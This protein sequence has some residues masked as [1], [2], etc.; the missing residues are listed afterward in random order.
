MLPVLRP[1]LEG[2]LVPLE[3]CLYAT[4][5]TSYLDFEKEIFITFRLFWR[6]IEGE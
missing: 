6:E 1:I 2:L 4:V 3:H 5:A